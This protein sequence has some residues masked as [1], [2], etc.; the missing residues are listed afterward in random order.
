MQVLHCSLENLQ[1]VHCN[2]SCSDYAPKDRS[3]SHLITHLVDSMMPLFQSTDVFLLEQQPPL[4]LKHIEQC[5]YMLIK[6]CFRKKHAKGRHVRLISTRAMHS[7]FAMS[8]DY[9]QRKVESIRL[10]TP[11]LR[12]HEQFINKVRK[13]DMSDATILILYFAQ[14]SLVDEYVQKPN[15][16]QHFAFVQN[17]SS[18]SSPN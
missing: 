4:G 17:T 7:F 12:T 11:Y 14:S 6:N 1:N 10:A 18:K 2:G 8:K 16:F 3:A 9:E 5:L 15:P 13:H